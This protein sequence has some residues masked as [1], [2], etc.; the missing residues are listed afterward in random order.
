MGR[1]RHG[2]HGQSPDTERSDFDTDTDDLAALLAGTPETS[3]AEHRPPAQRDMEADIPLRPLAAAPWPTLVICGT[4]EDTP[5]RYRR[6]A[7]ESLMAC[8]QATRPRSTRALRELW[9]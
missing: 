9:S 3:T 5:D 7:G 2:D 8:A 6:Y 1:E 4:W